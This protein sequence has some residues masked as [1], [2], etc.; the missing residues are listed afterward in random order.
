MSAAEKKK[1]EEEAKKKAEEDSRAAAAQAETHESRMER[2]RLDEIA[3][4]KEL[5]KQ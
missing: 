4:Q 2:D 1:M 5:A 3:R